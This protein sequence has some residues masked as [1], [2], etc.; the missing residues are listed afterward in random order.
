ME[1]VGQTSK[2]Q[3]SAV[4]IEDT[5]VSVLEDQGVIDAVVNIEDDMI[6]ITL[7]TDNGLELNLTVTEDEE[8]IVWCNAFANDE[9]FETSFPA[10]KVDGAIELSEIP[11]EWIGEI[12]S[13]L[14]GDS[15][16]FAEN[17]LP[18]LQEAKSRVVNGKIIKIKKKRR[19]TPAQRRALA[20][21]LKKARQSLKTD[22]DAKK[23]RAKS[24]KLR[25]QRNLK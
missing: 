7:E 19:L 18:V 6:G 5:L 17:Y 4:E 10:T 23:K 2:T 16:E 15:E 24:M 21:N 22:P 25:K 1:E 11:F 14:E 12:I 3:A 8:G 9:E 13:R 20:K